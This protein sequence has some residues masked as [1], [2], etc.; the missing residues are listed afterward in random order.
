[1]SSEIVGKKI[2]RVRSRAEHFRACSLVFA[3]KRVLRATVIT[4]NRLKRAVAFG[5]ERSRV[6]C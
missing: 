2:C 6:E 4:A 1:M 3:R 5:R